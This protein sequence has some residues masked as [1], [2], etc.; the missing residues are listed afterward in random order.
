MEDDNEGS[1]AVSEGDLRRITELRVVDLKTEL[2][3]R[4]LDINGNKSVL[5]ERL[6]Q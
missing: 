3:K 4:N 6:R 1:V 2:R 5:M